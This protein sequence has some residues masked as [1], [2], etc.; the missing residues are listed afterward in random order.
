MQRCSG[1]AGGD[2]I[3][4]EQSRGRGPR[5]PGKGLIK[6]RNQTAGEKIH[7]AA[8]GCVRLDFDLSGQSTVR[9]RPSTPTAS[10]RFRILSRVPELA[11]GFEL[12]T[13]TASPRLSV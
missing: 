10:L 5:R 2:D 8:F 6:E 4:A 7:C 13:Q 1:G 9:L 12:R 3:A 11:Q